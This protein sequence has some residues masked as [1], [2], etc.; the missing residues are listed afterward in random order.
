MLQGAGRVEGHAADWRPSPSAGEA[1]TWH[2]LREVAGQLDDTQCLACIHGVFAEQMIVLLHHGT[3]SGR[4]A[5]DRLYLAGFDVRPPGVDVA[6]EVVEGTGVIIHVMSNG[7]TT[8]S[9]GSHD[10]LYAER[11]EHTGGCGIDRWRHR[12]LYAIVDQENL[13][14]PSARGTPARSLRYT[15]FRAQ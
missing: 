2:D 12:W 13:P 4:V 11:V 10:G 1:L 7:T 14:R 6:S 3:T 5:D 8:S 9:A 15:D